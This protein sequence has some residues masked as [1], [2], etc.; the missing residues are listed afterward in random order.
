MKLF[1]EKGFDH[2]TVE[3]ITQVCGI[4]KGTFYNYFPRKEAILLHLGQTQM[5]AVQISMQRYAHISD[6][7]EKLTRLFHDLFERYSE[8][9]DMIKMTISEMMRSTLLFQEEMSIT[10]KFEEVLTGM[11]DDAKTRGQVDERTVTSDIAAILV[12]LYF[13]S[14][15]SWASSDQH[16]QGIESIFLRKFEIVWEGIRR[17]RDEA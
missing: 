13:Y 6:L 12:G 9:P 2:V 4:A 10:R 1:K 16:A 7:K 3:E 15:L 11:L 8:H 5:E 14:V 17:R